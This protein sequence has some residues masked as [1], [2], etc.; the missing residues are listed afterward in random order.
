MEM[1]VAVRRPEPD[2]EYVM[3]TEIAVERYRF[4]CGWCG[5]RFIRD[6]DVQ[7]VLDPDGGMWSFYW[8]DGLP[9]LAPTSGEELCPNCGRRMHVRLIARRDVPVADLGSDQPRQKVTTSSAER[10]AV[11]HLDAQQAETPLLPG[12]GSPAAE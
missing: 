9:A 1:T 4:E 7:Y 2:A 3:I 8:L 5:T 12:R 11:P 10:A 6:Y